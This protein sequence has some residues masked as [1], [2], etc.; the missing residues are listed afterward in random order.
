MLNIEQDTPLKQCTEGVLIP[1]EYH[2]I[3]EELK[4]DLQLC[5]VE[6]SNIRSELE[7]LRN[8]SQQVDDIKESF[9][10]IHLEECGNPDLY[11]REVANLQERITLLEAEKDSVLQ[12]W[13]ISLNTISALEEELRGIRTDGKNTKFYQEQVHIIKESYTEAIKMLEDKLSHVKDNFVKHQ[14]LYQTSK[15]RVENLTKEKDDLMEKYRSL[16]K[17]AQE[18]DRNNQITIETLKKDLAYAK[19][20]TNKVV[21]AKL[22]LEKKLNE[23][24]RYAENIAEKDRET[25]SRMAEA[26]ELIES[27]VREK[28]IVLHREAL[29]LEE[30]SRLEHRLTV[31]ANEYDTKIQELN[32]NTKEEIASNAERYLTEI[33]E[34]KA[35]LREK[36]SLA[37]KLERELKFTEE[38][39]DKMRIDSNAK[40]LNYEQ[41]IK[42]LELQMQ[43]YDESIAKNK[44]DMEI[45]QL[46]DKIITLESKL[47]TSN[48][49]LYKLAQQHS[50]NA[51]NQMKKADRENK[52]IMKHYSDLENQLAKTL[53]DKENLVLQLRSLKQDFDCEIQKRD[54]E[55]QSLENK[56]QV[57]E[58]NQKS[59]RVRENRLQDVSTDGI[60]TYPFDI[61]NKRTLDIKV[62]NK[63]HC[64]QSVLS[65]HVNKLQEKFDRKTREL[66]HH[67]QVH[68]KLSKKWRDEAK[69]LTAKFQGKAKELRA[70]IS[71]LQK[72]N[73][74][75]SKELL[76]CK[77][78][79][80]QFTLEDIQR[81]ALYF[82]IIMISYM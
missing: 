73:N 62:E 39:L 28:E 75:L 53:G 44:Y 3:M 71:I 35:E 38:K 50:M 65:D 24:K 47:A 76:T 19:T 6:Q 18:R 8:E 15:E 56:I 10:H 61:K 26:I 2:E 9:K 34:L 79:L 13:H 58:D 32:K 20:E 33:K 57:L 16:Q 63:C 69:S 59:N 43:V 22:E 51:E 81:Y 30:K 66:I 40:I 31:I 17:E 54:N 55:R 49:K 23:V 4:R 45:K 41:K 67:V 27:V 25:K 12:L 1:E 7:S 64:C 82:Q 74:E 21:Q 52:D 60:I 48:D 29:V 5:K 42:R 72:E 70:K 77:Q 80:A 37:D 46:K 68:Q 78:Q 11:K 36:T 14:T